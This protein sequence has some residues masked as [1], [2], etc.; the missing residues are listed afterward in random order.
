MKK[1]T[2]KIVSMALVAVM[3]LA[4][5][6]VVTPSVKAEA[7]TKTYN[8]FVEEGGVEINYFGNSVS[9]VSSTNS[10]VVGVKKDK[11]ASYKA[12]V[13]FKKAGKAT[14]TIRVKGY[15]S[16]ATK[17]YTFNVKKASSIL[18]PSM[19]TIGENGTSIL[20]SVKNSSNINFSSVQLAYTFRDNLG[21][22]IEAE[23]TRIGDV[24]AKKSGY[25][26]GYVSATKNLDLSQ[27]SVTVSS[28]SR[29]KAL[30]TGKTI[31]SSSYFAKYDASRNILT[32]KNK[33]VKKYITIKAYVFFYDAAG[34]ILD[35]TSRSQYLKKGQV[36]TSTVSSPYHGYD[37]V[38]VVTNAY[39]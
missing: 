17:K 4:T 8:V 1:V 24:G 18:K 14:V 19:Q 35:V 26:T 11:T 9:S 13:T 20:F 3:T 21:N 15:R 23:D 16:S 31:G 36:Q 6:F 2:S 30:E 7:A 5:A 39:R 37:H 38:K 10:K 28:L 32:F 33:S 22:T 34:N 25:N 12:V 29:S 27:S